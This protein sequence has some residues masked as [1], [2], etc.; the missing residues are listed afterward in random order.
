MIFLEDLGLLIQEREMKLFLII[1][2]S[3][4]K[5]GTFQMNCGCEY[6]YIKEKKKEFQSCST[7]GPNSMD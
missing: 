3:I 2:F 4:D 7:K 5:K 6:L 1:V